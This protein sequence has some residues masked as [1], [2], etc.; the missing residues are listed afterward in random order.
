M[1]EREVG[2][3]IADDQAVFRDAAR[4]VVEATPGFT[5]LG[6]A[7]CGEDAVSLAARLHP[8]LVIVDLRMP[9]ISGLQTSERLALLERRPFV[10]LVS[11]SDVP[12]LSELALEHGAFAFLS[13]RELRPSTL[14]ELWERRNETEDDERSTAA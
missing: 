3:V 11:V 13:K 5:L 7:V 8:D 2:V 1:S 10:V 12:G 4:A 14:R 6:E 9:D